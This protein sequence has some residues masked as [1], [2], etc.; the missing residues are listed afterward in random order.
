MQKSFRETDAFD[1]SVFDVVIRILQDHIQKPRIEQRFQK[2]L[3]AKCDELEI[4]AVLETY[5][6]IVGKA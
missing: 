4:S 6:G 1:E 3:P 5:Q 2:Q